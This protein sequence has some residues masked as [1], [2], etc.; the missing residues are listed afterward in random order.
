MKPGAKAD[1]GHLSIRV[2]PFHGAGLACS[3]YE[4]DLGTCKDN[5]PPN[6]SGYSLGNQTVKNTGAGDGSARLWIPGCGHGFRVFQAGNE[7]GSLI[8]SPFGRQVNG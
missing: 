1:R 7:T 3:I 8:G 4:S 6:F 5:R 2:F